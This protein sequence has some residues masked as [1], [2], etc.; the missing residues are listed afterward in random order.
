MGLLS[1]V[2]EDVWMSQYLNKRNIPQIGS[3]VNSGTVEGGDVILGGNIAFVGISTR[4]NENGAFQMRHLLEKEGY[5]VR[6]SKIPSPFLHIGGAMSIINED[7]ILCVNKVFPSD[8]FAG[9][10]TIMIPNDG[11]I[12]G[13]VITLGKKHLIANKNNLNAIQKLKKANFTVWECNLSEFTKGTGGPSCLIMP[14]KR[15]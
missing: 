8:F 7:T 13:N 4:T 12:S 3:I 1:R 14:L 11:F 2:G 6:I 9:F 5:V 10:Q 15:K